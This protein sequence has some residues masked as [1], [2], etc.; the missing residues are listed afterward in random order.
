M[1]KLRKFCVKSITDSPGIVIRF[2][3]L[4]QLVRCTF[5]KGY[6]T[7]SQK[8]ALREKF[9]LGDKMSRTLRLVLRA[10]KP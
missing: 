8:F 3:A 10:S 7:W 5:R 6:A 9:V 1:I 4:Y 2:R